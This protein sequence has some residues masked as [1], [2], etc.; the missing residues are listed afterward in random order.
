MKIPCG[1]VE[2]RLWAAE[3]LLT[4]QTLYELQLRAG[5]LPR[6]LLHG[7]LQLLQHLLLETTGREL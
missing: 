3:V 5:R 4:F 2:E 7:A 1:R 6:I